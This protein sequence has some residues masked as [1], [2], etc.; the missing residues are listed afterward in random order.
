MDTEEKI[1]VY[2]KIANGKTLCLCHVRAKKCKDHCERAVVTRD[3]YEDWQSAMKRDQF[4][5]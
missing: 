2:I 1:P 4:G 5:R 3:K